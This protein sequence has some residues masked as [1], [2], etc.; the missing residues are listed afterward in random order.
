MVLRCPVG[1]TYV[2]P[3]SVW[4]RSLC[5][6]Y[7]L[8]FLWIT[9]Q[10]YNFF[11]CEKW[12]EG[13]ALE[14]WESTLN[15]CVHAHGPDVELIMEA[16]CYNNNPLVISSSRIYIWSFA[17][18]VPTIWVFFDPLSRTRWITCLLQ[19]ISLVQPLFC[20]TFEYYPL[21]SREYHGTT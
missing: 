8:A 18:M 4:T 15:L 2:F 19:I 9:F 12:M 16:S 3:K 21:V 20:Y 14:K 13:C 17:T 10:R 11:E 7:L 5:G 6:L 1:W